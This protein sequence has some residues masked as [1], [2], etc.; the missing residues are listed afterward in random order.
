MCICW[1]IAI[2][3]SLGKWHIYI[4]IYIRRIARRISRKMVLEPHIYIYISIYG[5]YLGTY[6]FCRLYCLICSR[7]MWK[8]QPL[9]VVVGQLSA[10]S[11]RIFR[12][13]SRRPGAAGP[14]TALALERPR[15]VENRLLPQNGVGL[16]KASKVPKTRSSEH[17]RPWTKEDNSKS[18][19]K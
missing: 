4:Y 12:K 14:G 1:R 15:M 18:H 3:Q 19:E 8:K 5:A 13:R 16:G 2:A 6:Q 10:H 7:N 11:R 9:T 17:K